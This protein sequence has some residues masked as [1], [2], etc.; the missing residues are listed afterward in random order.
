MRILVTGATGFL[1]NNLVR[2]LL[3]QNHEIVT[4]VR[5]SSDQRSLDGLKI[6]KSNSSLTNPK[7]V[8]LLVADLDLIVHSAAMIQ[9]GWSNL[10]SSRKFNVG[11]TELLAQ[12]ARRKNIRMIH[13]STV[14]TFPSAGDGQPVSESTTG[15]PKSTCSYVVSKREAEAAFF[16]EIDR[17]LDGVIVNPGFMVGP[18]DW[19]PSSG[20]MMLAISKT[21]NYFA[22]AGGCSVVDV[23]DVA[24]GIVLAMRK[25]RAGENYILGGENLTYLELWQK[26]AAAIGC[27]KPKKQLPNWIAATAGR[28]GDLISKFTPTEL[29]VNSA[30]TAMGQMNHWYSSQKAID[31]L[32]YKIGDV[33]VA[34]NDAWKWFQAYGYTKRSSSDS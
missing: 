5:T 20:Q 34:L 17:G 6:E 21:L 26:M 11:A 14:D 33:D 19:K 31:E 18:N 27:S 1:G 30:A 24:D 29:A 12:A 13:V 3:E 23:R 16:S 15:P 10:K 4:T 32:G 22:P 8:G 9:V 28:F 2:T 25:G 7:E